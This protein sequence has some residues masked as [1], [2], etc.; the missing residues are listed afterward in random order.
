MINS[1]K[2]VTIVIISHKSKKKVIKLIS[3][4]SKELK[5]IVIENSEDKTIEKEKG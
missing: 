4:I 1:K 5:I 2:E 3:N